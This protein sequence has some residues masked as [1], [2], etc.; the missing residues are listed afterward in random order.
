MDSTYLE[1]SAGLQTSTKTSMIWIAGK[2]LDS[3]INLNEK[4]LGEH[5]Y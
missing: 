5:S 4:S 1:I 3:A 2:R